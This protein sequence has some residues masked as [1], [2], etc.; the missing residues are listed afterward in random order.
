MAENGFKLSD[1]HLTSKTFMGKTK[2]GGMWQVNGELRK[3]RRRVEGRTSLYGLE[4]ITVAA[5][6][7]VAYPI[8]TYAH[9]QRS[10]RY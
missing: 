2:E 3:R 6:S 5:R 1:C 7:G 9:K 10:D 8:N 4:D